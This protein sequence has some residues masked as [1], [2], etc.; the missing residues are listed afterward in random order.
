MRRRPPPRRPPPDTRARPRVGRGARNQVRGPQRRGGVGPREGAVSANDRGEQRGRRRAERDD[1]A[2]AG[3]AQPAHQ[4]SQPPA[5]HGGLDPPVGRLRD[6]HRHEQTQQVD[7]P[8]GERQLAAEH[9]DRPMIEVEPVRPASDGDHRRPRQQR[10]HHPAAPGRRHD[11]HRGEQPDPQEPALGVEARVELRHRHEPHDE[12]DQRRDPGGV[13]AP[14]GH[15]RQRRR[16]RGRP[17]H[18]RQRRPDQEPGRAGVGGV[19]GQRA[20]VGVV[21]QRHQQRRGERQQDRDEQRGGPPRRRQHP[22]QQERPQ[23]VQLPL[24]R[25]RPQVQQ[26]RRPRER[27]RVRQPGHHEVPV[28]D[29]E[30]R[31]QPV[32]PQPG[33]RAPARRTG[34][35]WRRRT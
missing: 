27:L 21:A 8:R 25:Q 13:D 18:P 11:Q 29:V 30:Q 28:L 4:R 22:D 7:L 16:P 26:R 10:G 24:H 20:A 32:G 3:A 1:G 33:R 5:P 35:A 12:R 34:R 2:R 23:Q 19:V 9:E 15:A 31:G 14:A 6:G 17:P